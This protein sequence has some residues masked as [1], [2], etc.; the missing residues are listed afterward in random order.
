LI[1]VRVKRYDC[2]FPILSP[3]ISFLGACR[4]NVY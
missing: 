2:A 3:F 1:A 4:L